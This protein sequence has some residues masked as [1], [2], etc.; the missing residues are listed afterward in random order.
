VLSRG[1]HVDARAA[2]I[3]YSLVTL[4]LFAGSLLTSLG[5]MHRVGG[6]SASITAKA[7]P[8]ILSLSSARTG[9]RRFEVMADD[10]V[11]RRW[12]AVSALER[13][14]LAEQL[15]G[16]GA[17]LTAYLGLPGYEGE[18]DDR[19][20]LRARL[21]DLRATLGELQALSGPR[22]DMTADG[23]LELR[24]KRSV[25]A[26]DDAVGVAMISSARSATGLAREIDAARTEAIRV[27]LSLGAL[28][29]A[30][31]AVLVLLVLRIVRRHSDVLERNAE[32]ERTR[33]NEL[34]LFSAR[35]AHDIRGPLAAVKMGVDLA[36]RGGMPPHS[37]SEALERAQ[38]SLRR[39][40]DI[41]DDL[42]EFAGAARPPDGATADVSRV[43]EGVLEDVAQRG[44]A[45]GI[46]L[47]YE[48]GER[49]GSVACRPGV[50]ASIASNLLQNAVKF[51]G[52][53][54][55]R[56][57]HV[58]AI[59]RGARVRLEFQDSGPGIPAEAHARIFEPYARATPAAAPG[60][61]LGLATVKRLVSAHGGH[62]WVRSAVGE[63]SL[64][65]VEL[66]RAGGGGA[67]A[68]GAAGAEAGTPKADGGPLVEHASG[69]AARGR[70]EP[71]DVPRSGPA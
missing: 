54:P 47:R 33:A 15:A 65:V 29:L 4:A 63:G 71:G 61:G 52:E 26:L 27:A 28:S 16:V 24:L 35:M 13:A 49:A 70:I 41:I 8:G 18:Q 20:T 44:A 51:M 42:Y 69:P 50:L 62:V 39:A 57:I 2:V 46:D 7:V 10:A 34:E 55:I 21:R 32:L 58:R 45:S 14:T 9:L 6:A 19:P 48:G 12:S 11:D 66:P 5:A 17:D 37:R 31:S 36:G 25:D 1:R 68:P 43:L 22:Q 67:L 60:L 38:R 40:F 56:R 64:F 3:G 30:L 23:I 59:D 53:G